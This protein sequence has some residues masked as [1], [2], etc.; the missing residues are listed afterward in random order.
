[1]RR[2][3]GVVEL[4]AGLSDRLQAIGGRVRK[5]PVRFKFRQRLVESISSPIVSQSARICS[6]SSACEYFVPLRH[7]NT[8][9]GVSLDPCS[10]S[11]WSKTVAGNEIDSAA[12]QTFRAGFSACQVRRARS[13][14][15]ATPRNRDRHPSDPSP[16]RARQIRRERG[17]RPPAASS[18]RRFARSLRK[19]SSLRERRARSAWRG[20]FCKRF[21]AK[22]ARQVARSLSICIAMSALAEAPNADSSRS[23][24][25]GDRADFRPSRRVNC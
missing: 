19:T 3:H 4:D 12:K 7:Q 5:I 13:K 6:R 8:R 1:M 20:K 17:A 2:L 25:S 16:R 14:R 15:R 9:H 23:A 21:D 22:P 10:D 18:S 11:L 24:I